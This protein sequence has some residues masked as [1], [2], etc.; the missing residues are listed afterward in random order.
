MN[1]YFLRVPV[2]RDA[3]GQR[4]QLVVATLHGRIGFRLSIL[5]E[6]RLK[7]SGPLIE[8][9]EGKLSRPVLCLL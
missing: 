3:F 9:P 6:T 1:L 7:K 5:E 8:R 2:I 4:L